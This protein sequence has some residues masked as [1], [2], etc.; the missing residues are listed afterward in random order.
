MSTFTSLPK[1]MFGSRPM[2]RLNH[3]AIAQKLCLY[4]YKT[5]FII[6]KILKSLYNSIVNNITLISSKLL[7][8]WI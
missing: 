1:A 4:K 8:P 3:N 7:L 6:F 5:I 2:A